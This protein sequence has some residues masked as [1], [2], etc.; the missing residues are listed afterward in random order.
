MLI[1]RKLKTIVEQYFIHFCDRR[2]KK[3]LYS[4][5][6]TK[7]FNIIEKIIKLYEKDKEKS[8]FIKKYLIGRDLW[9]DAHFKLHIERRT[10]FQWKD[11][12]LS[13]AV[14]YAMKDNLIEIE[15]VYVENVAL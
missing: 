13:D 2:K 4:D 10:Y 12:I 3:Y 11:E 5:Y 7:M 14:I 9:Q 15:E 1:T 6:D 8:F